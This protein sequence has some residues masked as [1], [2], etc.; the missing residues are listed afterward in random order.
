MNSY[1]DLLDAAQREGVQSHVVGIV[2]IRRGRILLLKRRTDDFM[3]GMWE[4]PGGHVDPGERIPDAIARELEEETGL[5]LVDIVSPEGGFD[6]D[7]EFGRTRQWNFRVTATGERITHPEH[8]EYR[9]VSPAEL[10]TLPMTPEMRQSLAQL[11]PT[12]RP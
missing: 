4:I 9:W 12:E 3:P 8:S 2:L 7:G 6:Y 11:I 1:N 5:T 10:A